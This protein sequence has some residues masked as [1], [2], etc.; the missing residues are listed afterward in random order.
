MQ[1]SLLLLQLACR[2]V[3]KTCRGRAVWGGD[4]E[5]MELCRKNC[6][7]V[8]WDW[9]LERYSSGARDLTSSGQD[10]WASETLPLL[11]SIRPKLVSSV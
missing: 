2:M 5:T 1:P 7:A 4:Q 10:E 8:C 11:A 3:K 9:L 6:L